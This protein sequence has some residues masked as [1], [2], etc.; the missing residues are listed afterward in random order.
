MLIR[1]RTTKS[2]K[3]MNEVFS[4]TLEQ[5]TRFDKSVVFGKST[6]KISER[7]SNSIISLVYRYKTMSRSEPM[8]TK[9]S[10]DTTADSLIALVEELSLFKECL[11]QE[12]STKLRLVLLDNLEEKVLRIL[13]GSSEVVPAISKGKCH[14]Y[15]EA[16]EESTE[17]GFTVFCHHKTKT[18]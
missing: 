7:E 4:G 6:I 17:E 2:S 13:P 15:V 12:K 16:D 5:L 9:I 18:G 3:A 8:S 11:E 1:C 14:L 10:K